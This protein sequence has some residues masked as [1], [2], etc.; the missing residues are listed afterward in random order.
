ML[1]ETMVRRRRSGILRS[2]KQKIEAGEYLLT[3]HA[4][5]ELDEDDI[6]E[7]ELLWVIRTSRLERTLTDDP[8][9]T[10]YVLRGRT[11]DG[12]EA[13]VVCRVVEGKIRILTAYAVE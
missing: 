2:I 1:G 9:G 4:L 12:Y 8:R 6:A 3:D 10:R 13:E 11:P 5:Q 7:G